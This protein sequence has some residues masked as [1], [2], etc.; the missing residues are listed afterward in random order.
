MERLRPDIYQEK[1]SDIPFPTLKE[2]G[3]KLLL[4]DIDNTLLACG[5]N[6]IQE[7]IEKE[8]EKL[9]NEFQ[10]ILFSNASKKRVKELAKILNLPSVFRA[11]KPCKRAFIKVIKENKLEPCEVAIIGDQILTDIKGGNKVGIT[12]ILVSPLS[13]M[14]DFF[15]RLNR[16]REESAFKKMSSK[17]LF[18]KGR[19]YE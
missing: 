16:K 3:I 11:F 5:E 18:F 13:E 17:G 7:N 12:T 2:N 19:Y 1:I 14:D 15:T 8:I 9:K 4:I 10:I 6:E